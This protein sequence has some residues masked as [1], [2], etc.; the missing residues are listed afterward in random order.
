MA[1]KI[2]L[3]IIGTGRIV[4]R[5][6]N[7]LHNAREIEVKAIAGRS[8][9]K[10]EATAQQWGIP[11]AFSSYEALAESDEI[12]LAYIALPNPFHAQYACLM[13]RSGK[14]VLC[15]KPLAVSGRET[16]GLIDCAR[17][18]GVFL[19]EAMWTRFL[20]SMET[21]TALIREGVIGEIRHVFGAFS[22]S[23]AQYDPYDRVFD[24]ALAGG[25]LLDIGVY[26][27]MACTQ[28]L[29]WQ[30]QR[31][32]SLAVKTPEGVD[33][34]T[35]LQML[36]PSG[37][38]AQIFCGMDARSD[39]VLR[40][41]GTK[42]YIEMPGSWHPVAFTVYIKGEEPKNYS[43]PPENEGHHYEFDH[44]ARCIRAGLAESPVIPW[45]ESL[46]VADIC[47]KARHEN[48]IFYPG[49]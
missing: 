49:E 30:P 20:P 43:F 17:E 48:G 8:R 47:T 39:D 1:E 7:D 11:L 4:K 21:M 10:A 2:R 26:P 23:L 14:H 18:N 25:A 16:R 15:E 44:A 6:M 37:A 46:A 9:E 31:V 36:Y 19:M 34:R 28:L 24:P 13:M 41:F 33:L 29:G 27:L 38:T 42:G 35:E 40:V 3:G 5:V 45:E 22:Y 12:D 32:Q